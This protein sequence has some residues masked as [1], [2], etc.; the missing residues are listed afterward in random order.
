MDS[1]EWQST[2]HGVSKSRTRLS[3]FHFPFIAPSPCCVTPPKCVHILTGRLSLL[4]TFAIPAPD[5]LPL[6]TTSLFLS[7]PVANL[8]HYSELLLLSTRPDW[9]AKGLPPQE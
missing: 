5:P 8:C 1:G 4:T 3:D 9:R 2:V 6:V 7:V